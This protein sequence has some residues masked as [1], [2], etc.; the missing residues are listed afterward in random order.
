MDGFH[1]ADAVLVAT[2]ARDRK[3]APDTFDADGY[4]AILERLRIADATVY[5]PRF[6]RAI[7]DSIAAA[8][9]VPAGAALVIT[10]GNYLLHW[11]RARRALDEVWFVDLPAELRRDRLIARHIAFGRSPADARSFALGSDERNAALI[12]AG[13]HLADLVLTDD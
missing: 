6:D 2:G 4:I 11:P 9:A 13:R 10:E 7:E 8:I 5:A 3:G 12:E 1:I